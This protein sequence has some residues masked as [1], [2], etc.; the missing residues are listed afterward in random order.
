MLTFPVSLVFCT[1]IVDQRWKTLCTA[2][3]AVPMAALLMTYSRSGWVSFALPAAVFIAL[4]EKRLLPLMALAALA[5]VPVLP[6]SIFNRILTIGSTAD[7]S[8]AY[9]LFIW[10]SAL[11]MI[12]DCGLTGIGLGPGN[13][14]PLY[15]FYSYPTA[16]TAYHSHMLYLEVWLEMG[17]LGIVSFLGMYLGIIRRAIRAMAKADSMVRYVLIAC[18]SSLVGV[19]F[20][21]AAEYIWFYPRILFAFFILIGVTLAAVKLSEESE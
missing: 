6:D 11:K 5:A 20:V 21:G 4:G 18:V 7:S 14:I 16:R 1:N 3:L 13:F 15:H 9:R 12:R 10:A 19:S 8:N 17:L 2:T